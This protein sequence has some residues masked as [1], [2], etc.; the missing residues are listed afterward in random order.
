MKIVVRVVFI[1]FVAFS[2]C[3]GCLYEYHDEYHGAKFIFKLPNQEYITIWKRNVNKDY[4]IGD[5]LV[6]PGRFKGFDIP[7]TIGFIEASNCS[8][9]RLMMIK[10]IK[11][12]LD[13]V[14]FVNEEYSYKVIIKD[15]ADSKIR[16]YNSSTIKITQSIT[17]TGSKIF[18]G[19]L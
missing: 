13:N 14:I 19:I 1:L 3:A 8:I 15:K 10:N 16:L 17:L 6:I 4:P 2:L 11:H 9:I 7:D 5:V 12:S 18:F